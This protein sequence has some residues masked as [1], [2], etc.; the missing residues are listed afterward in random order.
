MRDEESLRLDEAE[1]TEM[2]RIG[3]VTS[4]RSDLGFYLPLMRAIRGH[5]R[6]QLEIV[7]TGMHLAPAFGLTV[8]HIEEAG[9]EVAHSVESLLASDT[10]SGVAKSMGVGLAGFS[11]LFARWRPDL[12]V[13]FGDRFD[14]Y[15][16]ALAA[17][18]FRL[19][20]AHIGGGEM[21]EGAIDDG[22]RHSLTKLSHLHFVSTSDAAERVRQLGEEPWR[23]SV[24][25]ALSLDAIRGM[26]LD[27]KEETARRFGFDLAKPVA[28][29]TYHPVTLEYDQAAWQVAQLLGALEQSGL[30]CVFTQPNADTGAHQ[31]R[32]AIQRFCT[33][34]GDRRVVMN[35]GQREY[36]SLLGAVSVMVGNSSSGLVEA[37]SFRLPVVNIGT[38]QDGRLRAANVI[39]CGYGTPAIRGALSRAL[40]PAFRSALRDVRNPYGDGHAAPRIVDRLAAIEDF[41]GLLRKTF[42]ALDGAAARARGRSGRAPGSSAPSVPWAARAI[43]H[44]AAGRSGSAG[45]MRRRS[46]AAEQPA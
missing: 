9:L 35:A 44:A 23:V 33:G 37:P 36:F 4:S 19:P 43:R 27:T 38:R 45:R 46:R 8:R 3:I 18:P 39:D 24:C 20:V 28:L 31:V 12:L 14:M 17:L 26:E 30:Q 41:N 16:A 6:L 11:D 25:G 15:P 5:P 32:E 40:S 10:P 2:T 42:A 21:T 1:D 29:V 7:A 34:R 22:L 13:V